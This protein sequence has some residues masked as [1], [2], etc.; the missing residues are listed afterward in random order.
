[1]KLKIY[2][3]QEEVVYIALG[4]IEEGIRVVTVDNDGRILWSL[5]EIRKDGIYLERDVPKYLGFD[6]DEK[7]RLKIIE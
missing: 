1:M 6:L 7:G 4:E 3:G 5:F 2:K